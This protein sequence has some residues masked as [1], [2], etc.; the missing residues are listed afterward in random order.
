MAKTA[1][2]SL[3]DRLVPLLTQ[4]VKLLRGIHGEVADIK[5][6]L[7]SIQ[8]FLKDADARAAAEEDTSEGVKTWVKHV[9][10][11][12]FRIDIAINRYF[13]GVAQHDPHRGGFIGLVHKVAHFLKT[14]K[15]RHKMASEIQGIKSSFQKIK[16]RRDRYPFEVIDQGSSSSTSKAHDPRKDSLY[17]DDADIVGIEIPRDTLISWLVNDQPHRSVLSVVGMGGSGKTTLVKKVYDH[18]TVRGCFDCRAWISVS[19]SYN[20]EDL[21]RR[22]IK[23]FCE[24]TP[25]GVDSMDGDSLIELTL[26]EKLY[27]VKSMIYCMRSSYKRWKI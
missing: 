18:Q 22:M 26:V 25:K 8:S 16:E 11:V 2:S 27:I 6:E 9:Q 10:E 14:L 23:K 19:Q 4:E 3:I 21:L 12:A 15:P 24:I 13:V 7:K 1:M 20:K 5:D 17:L